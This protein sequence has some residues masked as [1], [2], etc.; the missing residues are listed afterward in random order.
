M[1][2]NNLMFKNKLNSLAVAVTHVQLF[3]CHPMFQIET[4]VF[5][6]TQGEKKPKQP[7]KGILPG[8]D[9]TK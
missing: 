7:T 5:I 4:F 2:W 8:V 3:E 1:F 6:R 9:V